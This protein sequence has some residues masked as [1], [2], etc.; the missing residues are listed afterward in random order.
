MI[1]QKLEK[2]C[3]A[4]GGKGG[5]GNT[6]FKVQLI[7]HQEVYKGTLGEEFVIGFN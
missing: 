4:N 2:V 3:A 5:L 7:E 1:L 6:R